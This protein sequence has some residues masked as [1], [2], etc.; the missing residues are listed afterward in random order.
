MNRTSYL[1][2]LVQAL[3]SFEFH[4]MEPAPLPHLDGIDPLTRAVRILS[5][6]FRQVVFVTSPDGML[7]G[8]IRYVVRVFAILAVPLLGV[9]GILLLVQIVLA[10]LGGILTSTLGVGLILLAV[11]MVMAR[12]AR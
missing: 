12:F 2:R 8:V 3:G 4:P 10:Q 5:W 7:I 6:R 11:A 9:I 1:G